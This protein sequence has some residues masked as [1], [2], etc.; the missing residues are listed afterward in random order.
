MPSS[1]R[2]FA[3]D[4]SGNGSSDLMNN[5]TDVIGSVANYLKKNGWHGGKPIAV[6]AALTTNKAKSLATNKRRPNLTTSQLKRAGITPEHP[7]AGN[8]KVLLVK[9]KDKEGYEYWL[10]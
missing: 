8:P 5:T 3:I 7:I 2:N 1:Y 4:F 9:L 6:K 10:G